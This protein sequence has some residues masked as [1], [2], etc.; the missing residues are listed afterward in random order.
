MEKIKGDNKVTLEL[1]LNAES[2]C[3]EKYKK[4]IL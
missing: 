1:I 3:L 2:K 4:I